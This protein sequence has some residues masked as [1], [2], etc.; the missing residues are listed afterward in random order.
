MEIIGT[1]HA[2]MQQQRN[3]TKAGLR[4][5]RPVAI[6][7]SMDGSQDLI[8]CYPDS[9]SEKKRADGEQ[10]PYGA[11]MG[12]VHISIRMKKNIPKPYM[13]AIGRNVRTPVNA[14]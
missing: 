11:D 1:V 3:Q 10:G 7:S 5:V 12:V 9:S 14:R 4:Y 8:C 2:F 13:S 6:C